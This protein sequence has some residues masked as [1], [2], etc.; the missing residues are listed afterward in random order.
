MK[1]GSFILNEVYSDDIDTVIQSRPVLEAPKRRVTFK[2]SFGKSGDIP[3]DEE[4]YDN[5]TLQLSLST[6]GRDAVHSR[7]RIFELFDSGDYMNLR[8]YCDD[9]KYYRVLVTDPPKFESRYYMGEGM[10][11]DVTMTV[12]P[13]KILVNSRQLTLTKE[14]QINNPTNK[15]SLP[16]VTIYGTGDITLLVEG[17]PFVMKN[18]VEHITLDS[19]LMFA[20]KTTGGV[21]LNENSKTFTRTFP[22]F[23]PGLNSVK[24]VGNVIKIDIL[25]QWRTL[26]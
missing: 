18:V 4:S 17:R 16:I 2:K 5:T 12:K 21:I 22:F 25:P 10:S 9:T 13:Y 19:E 14:E 26:V 15:A 7:E 24:W 11:Y 1:A 8:M 20:Y 6:D 3:Y 23:S